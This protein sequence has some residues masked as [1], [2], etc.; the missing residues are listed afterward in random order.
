MSSKPLKTKGKPPGV[1]VG[2]LRAV[3]LSSAFD[4]QRGL[5]KVFNEVRRGELKEGTARTLIYC[6]SVMLRGIEL[7]AIEA[8]LSALEELVRAGK[9]S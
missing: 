7:V 1:A 2:S 3:R 6:L 9:Q 4:V 8:R 5:G